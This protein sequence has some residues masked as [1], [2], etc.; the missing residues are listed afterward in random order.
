M[1]ARVAPSAQRV[2][3]TPVREL[4]ERAMRMD[5]VLKLYFGESSIPTPEFIKQ[6]A[7]RALQ[8][9]YTFYSENAGLPSL[10]RALARHYARLHGVEPD[11]E[12]EIVVTA[13]GVQALN[14][15]IR[16]VL[17][18][19]DEALVLTPVWP[20]GPANVI[21]AG[22]AV[23]EVPHARVG[24]RYSVDF[25]ALRSALTSRTRLLLYTSPSNPLGW[26][27]TRE[28]QERL[29]A[30][31]REHELWLLADEVYERLYW[32]TGSLGEPAPSILR[33]VRREDA[34]IVVQSFS[35]SYSMTG[36]RVG[37]LVARAD[38]AA[39]AAQLNEYIVSHA[40]TF[41]QK[42][43]E[44]ALEHGEPE[45]RLMLQRLKENRDLALAAL[46][47]MPRVTVAEPEGAFYLF[48]RIAGVENAFAF[49]LRLL[50]ERR[51]G[52]APGSAFGAG[53]EGAVRLCF[54]ADRRILEEAL[55]RLAEFLVRL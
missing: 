50:E 3:Y 51:V 46:R 13:S 8:E 16:A 21:L 14:V 34:V 26:V 20:N 28:E 11:P 47:A 19:G 10:R 31:A 30:F 9:N 29:L 36:W 45:L 27:A 2:P 44:I 41:V 48:P 4:A 25:D 37:W 55:D 53:G 18:P 33:L 43:A 49:C 15:A 24:G 1:P 38:L 42:A 23:R 39:R 52:L 12:R 35:K 17:D 5:G 6:A 54:A 40:P 7:C 32:R 22:G